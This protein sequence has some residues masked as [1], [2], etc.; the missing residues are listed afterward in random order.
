MKN[1]HSTMICI[2]VLS[3]CVWAAF[4]INHHTKVVK[5]EKQIVTGTTRPVCAGRFV[6]DLP[7]QAVVTYR[8]ATV[9][10]WEI[11]TTTETDDE[12]ELRIG[13]KEEQIGSSRN[14]RDG[15][16]LELVHKFK[17]N[18]LHG[19]IFLYDR[20]WTG[21]MRAGKEVV[22]ES[23]SID[24]SVRASGISYDF[25]AQLRKPEKLQRLE[26]LLYQLQPVPEGEVP[27][28]PGFCFDRG[29]LRDPLTIDDHEYVSVFWGTTEQP[30][31]A[32]SFSTFAGTKPG[33][34]LLQRHAASD[35]QQQYAPH[36]HDLRTGPRVINGVAGEEVLQ[37]VDELNGVKLQ[38]FMWESISDEADLSLPMLT[39][40]LSTGLGR[41]GKPVNSSLS[42][43]DALALWEQISSSLR[44]RSTR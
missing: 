15:V 13:R 11:S 38:D 20:K 3:A 32:G 6:L 19:K 44:R 22:S 43:S 10:G 37:R 30:D 33:Q 9:A 14:E 16:S 12:F 42:D 31:L 24:A 36:F 34:T 17:S 29:L 40:E 18:D 41:P 35:I 1:Q 21:L 8:R 7:Q 2:V 39:L 27:V 28:N 4:G 26:K 25:T 5:M 23:V